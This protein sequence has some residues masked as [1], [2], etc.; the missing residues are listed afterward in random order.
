MP[1]VQHHSSDY[2]IHQLY[3][4]S[5]GVFVVVTILSLKNYQLDSAGIVVTLL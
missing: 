5:L 2:S 1:S 4:H 3:K